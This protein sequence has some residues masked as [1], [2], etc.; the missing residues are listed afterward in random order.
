MLLL[1]D[2]E[3]AFESVSFNIILTTFEIFEFGKTLKLGL[4]LSWEW[5]MEIF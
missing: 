1:I 4:Q 5:K 2:F 3:K